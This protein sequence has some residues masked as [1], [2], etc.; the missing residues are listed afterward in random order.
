MVELESPDWREPMRLLFDEDWQ[1]AG[2]RVPVLAPVENDEAD[3]ND[4]K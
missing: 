4:E 2:V 1:R 3:E